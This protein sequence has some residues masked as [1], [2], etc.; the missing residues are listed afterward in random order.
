MFISEKEQALLQILQDILFIDNKLLG[1]SIY[2]Y[3][4]TRKVNDIEYETCLFDIIHSILNDYR[5]IIL[6]DYYS[7]TED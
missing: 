5:N 4:F 7:E 3:K 6:K 1:T 2:Y